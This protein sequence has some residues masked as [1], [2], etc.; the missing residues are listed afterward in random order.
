MKKEKV[1]I[2]RD[3]KLVIMPML[4]ILCVCEKPENRKKERL[5]TMFPGTYLSY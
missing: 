2:Y 4:A 5:N 3:T 1:Q